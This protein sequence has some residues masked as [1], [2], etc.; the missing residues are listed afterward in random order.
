MI[1][2]FQSRVQDEAIAVRTT[3]IA[4]VRSLYQEWNG[5]V[6]EFI[7]DLSNGF[8]V[9]TPTIINTLAWKSITELSEIPNVNS[10]L[11]NEL[12]FPDPMRQH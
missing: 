12:H 7:T 8:T 6:L 1:G 3:L 2:R 9:T 10:I 11:T 4:A 5:S